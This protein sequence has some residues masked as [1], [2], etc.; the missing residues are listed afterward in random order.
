VAERVVS[1]FGRLLN[2]EVPD[3]VLRER[4]SETARPKADVRRGAKSI[5]IFRIEE[6]WLALPTEAF[7]EAVENCT[8]HA[9]SP[10][11]RNTQRSGERTRRS[12]DLCEPGSVLGRNADTIRTRHGRVLSHVLVCKRK[13][14]RI[15]FPVSEVF[16]V[17]RYDSEDL[18]KVPATLSNSAAGA[19]TMGM[20]GWNGRTVGCLDDELVFYAIGKSL[21]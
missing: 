16:G 21:L 2:R 18:R 17:H 1:S 6:E 7:Q 9:A 11:R 13:G 5:L 8:L 19:F 20:L 14:E 15:A 12:P 4:T 3:D 10:A